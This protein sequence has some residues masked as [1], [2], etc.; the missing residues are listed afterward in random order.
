MVGKLLLPLMMY[1]LGLLA[2]VS[3]QLS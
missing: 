1:N 2:A 3:C